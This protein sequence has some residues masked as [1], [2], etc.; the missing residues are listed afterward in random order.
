M[1]FSYSLKDKNKIKPFNVKREKQE[2][3]LFFSDTEKSFLNESNEETSEGEEEFQR[4][5]YLT[6]IPFPLSVLG[7]KPKAEFEFLEH[8]SS[9]QRELDLGSIPIKNKKKPWEYFIK[10][11]TGKVSAILKTQKPQK[12]CFKIFCFFQKVFFPCFKSTEKTMF[13]KHINEE[14]FYSVDSFL[15]FNVTFISKFVTLRSPFFETKKGY[16]K[17]VLSIYYPELE[18]TEDLFNKKMFDELTEDEKKDIMFGLEK[19]I[20]LD[21]ITGC[22]RTKKNFLMLKTIKEEKSSFNNRKKNLIQTFAIE[23][24]KFS[25]LKTNGY[26]WDLYKIKERPFSDCLKKKVLPLIKPFAGNKENKWDELY[27]KLETR[28]NEENCFDRD[29]FEERICF[30]RGRLY[31]LVKCLERNEPIKKLLMKRQLYI[32]RIDPWRLDKYKNIHSIDTS[33]SSISEEVNCWVLEK[34]G[35]EIKWLVVSSEKKES[36]LFY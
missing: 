3:E 33:S 24:N 27:Y 9:V 6:R 4:V 15:G 28:L 7:F 1:I 11:K 2:N 20:M 31:N 13:K 12:V 23:N 36:F 34:E 26:N 10:D 32:Y 14:I 25:D 18:K 29:Q 22:L 21:Y 5:S 30:I 16:V 8:I 17:G 19:I 35:K